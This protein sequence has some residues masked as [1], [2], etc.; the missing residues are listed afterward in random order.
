MWAGSVET[1]IQIEREILIEFILKPDMV[2]FLEKE[3]V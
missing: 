1:D 2:V 3:S